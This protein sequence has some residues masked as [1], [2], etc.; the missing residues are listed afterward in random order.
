MKSPTPNKN[1]EKDFLCSVKSQDVQLGWGEGV[2]GSVFIILDEKD[3]NNFLTF[4]C[5]HLGSVA[6]SCIKFFT[7]PN[8][9]T[10]VPSSNYVVSNLEREKSFEIFKIKGVLNF[11]NWWKIGHRLFLIHFTQ[12]LT[13]FPYHHF[14]P[15]HYLF[16]LDR[17]IIPLAYQTSG[18]KIIFQRGEDMIFQENIHPCR[19]IYIP[20]MNVRYWKKPTSLVDQCSVFVLFKGGS[21]S[22]P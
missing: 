15:Y 4:D 11:K 19:I 16:S 22:S 2:L 10:L 13:Y 5:C 17:Q 3:N 20:K 1:P 9:F 21:T 6:N 7:S 8:S 14:F 12:K 18:E